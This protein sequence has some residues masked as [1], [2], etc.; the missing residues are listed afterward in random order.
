M[1]RDGQ[2]QP[3]RNS[4][5]VHISAPSR[6]RGQAFLTRS[7]GIGSRACRLFRCHPQHILLESRD[8]QDPRRVRQG[9]RAR[10]VPGK[11]CATTLA[12][13]SPP[14][15][16]PGPPHP[17]DVPRPKPVQLDAAPAETPEPRAGPEPLPPSPG[18]SVVPDR[19]R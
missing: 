1:G 3:R 9:R 17:G 7:L 13:L 2:D 16:S 5:W 10:A 6:C 19:V 14:V 18:T 11:R 8:L 12:S 4:A 15:L